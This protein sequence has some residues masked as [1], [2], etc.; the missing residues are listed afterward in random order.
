VPREQIVV[1]RISGAA[2]V[3]PLFAD[4][5][6]QLRDGDTLMVWKVDRLG[7]STIDALQTTSPKFI[8]VAPS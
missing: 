6:E 5:I 4:L 3:R 7:R 8:G 2:K 1:E